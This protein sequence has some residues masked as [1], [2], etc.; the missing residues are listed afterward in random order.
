M[1]SSE[2]FNTSYTFQT[3]V[4]TKNEGKYEVLFYCF[5]FRNNIL[6]Y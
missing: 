3:D 6:T 4:K 5:Y 2:N 1:E